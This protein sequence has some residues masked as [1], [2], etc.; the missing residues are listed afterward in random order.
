MSDKNEVQLIVIKFNN[1]TAI[2]TV[3]I[4]HSNTYKKTFAYSGQLNRVGARNI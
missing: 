4:K 2:F 1:C 3:F